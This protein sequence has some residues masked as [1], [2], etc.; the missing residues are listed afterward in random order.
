LAAVPPAV[1]GTLACSRDRKTANEAKPRTIMAQLYHTDRVGGLGRSL[2]DLGKPST[3][4]QVR[5]DIGEIRLDVQNR[6]AIEHI[7]SANV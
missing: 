1:V 3:P 7:D 4:Q 5:R 2:F 6:R